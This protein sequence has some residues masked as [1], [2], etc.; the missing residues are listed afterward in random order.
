MPEPPGAG[1]KDGAKRA[2][3]AGKIS[4]SSVAMLAGAV[5]CVA[6]LGCWFV[7]LGAVPGVAARETPRGMSA[8]EARSNR[9]LARDMFYHSYTNY[10]AH[11]FP[12][13][14]LAPIACKVRDS[15]R[16]TS[17]RVKSS[18]MPCK[19]AGVDWRHAI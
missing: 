16:R 7:P 8:E 5:V 17:C 10:M 12:R 9:E 15:W 18:L 1:G 3:G 19:R 4:T 2:S 6:Y 13:D 11:A 14:E